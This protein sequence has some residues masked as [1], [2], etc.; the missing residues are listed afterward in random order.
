MN[1]TIRRAPQALHANKNESTKEVYQAEIVRATDSDDLVASKASVP[2]SVLEVADA[3]AGN[4][5]I[6]YPNP[7]QG[8]VNV[9]FDYA[10]GE[11]VQWALINQ[12]GVVVERGSMNAGMEK[13][14]IETGD[15]PRGVYYLSIKGASHEFKYRK[16]MVNK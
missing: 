7:T 1:N 10:V 14:E 12:M 2:P 11:S 6:M 13:F 16:L 8:K 15:Y 3:L 9:K 5:F 4:D